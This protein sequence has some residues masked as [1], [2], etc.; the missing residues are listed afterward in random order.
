MEEKR[1]LK[2]CPGFYPPM[3]EI[4]LR[5]IAVHPVIHL[6]S[7]EMTVKYLLCVGNEDSFRKEDK[8]CN[9]HGEKIDIDAIVLQMSNCKS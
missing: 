6:F 7:E 8:L 9:L 4:P 5:R 1:G 3:R 2:G